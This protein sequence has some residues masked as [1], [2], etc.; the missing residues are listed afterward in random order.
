MNE[1]MAFSDRM[2]DS[3][4]A[5]LT[6]DLMF[7]EWIGLAHQLRWARVESVTSCK[8]Q[9]LQYLRI[10]ELIHFFVG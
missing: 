5:S 2:L 4:D 1:R 8:N 10:S 9:C 6:I 3:L 7:D